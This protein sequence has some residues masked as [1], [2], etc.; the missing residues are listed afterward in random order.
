MCNLFVPQVLE[1]TQFKQPPRSALDL[2]QTL[3]Q[4]FKQR[5]RFI[6]C[7]REGIGDVLK[8]RIVEN[9]A[10]DAGPAAIGEDLVARNAQRQL[11]KGRCRSYSSNFRTTIADTSW[12]MSCESWKSSVIERMYAATDGKLFVQHQASSSFEED[13]NKSTPVRQIRGR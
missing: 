4:R 1:I 11:I 9:L 6:G 7:L 3:L 10:I 13:A 12:R 2:L 5:V 8:S